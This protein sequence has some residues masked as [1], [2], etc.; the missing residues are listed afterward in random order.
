MGAAD[1]RKGKRGHDDNGNVRPADDRYNLHD[2]A[3]E[4]AVVRSPDEPQTPGRSGASARGRA[5]RGTNRGGA[6]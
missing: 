5:G 3:E 2:P 4:S 6:R 1:R